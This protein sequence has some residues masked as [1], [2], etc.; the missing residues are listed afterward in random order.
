MYRKKF[1]GVMAD[2]KKKLD[3]PLV[4]ALTMTLVV[5]GTAAILSWAL[6]GLGWTGPLGF[7]KGGVVQ[8]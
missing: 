8:S 6:M 2:V 7:F 1:G 5:F 3:N 4:F